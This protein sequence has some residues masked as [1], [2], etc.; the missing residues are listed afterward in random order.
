M[1]RMF[2]TGMM[3]GALGLFLSACD[4][5]GTSSSAG[6]QATQA[7]NKTA[8]YAAGQVQLRQKQKMEN[9]LNAIQQKQQKQY[10]QAMQEKKQ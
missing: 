2:F 6:Q 5:S 1:C 9:K 7:V 3:I 4:E 10:N 8:D